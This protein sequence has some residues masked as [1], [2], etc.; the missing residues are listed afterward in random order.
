MPKPADADLARVL[1]PIAR[2]L[3]GLAYGA[4]E[5]VVHDGRVVQIERREKFRFE[6]PP[7]I[8]PADGSGQA[9]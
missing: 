4:V 5:I 2:A 8:T 9:D 6:P 7:R 1:Q 3:S